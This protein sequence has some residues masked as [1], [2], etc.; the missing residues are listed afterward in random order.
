MGPFIINARI[1]KILTEYGI[2]SKSSQAGQSAKQKV[3]LHHVAPFFVLRASSKIK[4]WN[5][6]H[7]S[8]CM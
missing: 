8:N 4:Q 7:D 1:V 5:K 3:Q 2:E 6:C